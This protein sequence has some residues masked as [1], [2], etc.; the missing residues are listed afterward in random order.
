MAKA[1]EHIACG[2]GSAEQ[3]DKAAALVEEDQKSQRTESSA[4]VVSDKE[5]VVERIESGQGDG[6]AVSPGEVSFRFH[7]YY[8]EIDLRLSSCWTWS[9]QY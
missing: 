4:V 7:W 6:L 3:G 1:Q 5:A 9:G 8:S 2:N